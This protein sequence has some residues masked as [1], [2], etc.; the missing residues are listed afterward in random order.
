[1]NQEDCKVIDRVNR[2]TQQLLDRDWLEQGT[3]QDELDKNRLLL[4]QFNIA[5]RNGCS[6]DDILARW[7]YLP[8]QELPED[9]ECTR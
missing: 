8:A 6:I 7:D 9:K 5:M 4:E 3:T 2:L 1:M